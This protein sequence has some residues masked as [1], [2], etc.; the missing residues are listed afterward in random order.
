MAE[1]QCHTSALPALRDTG[2]H[3]SVHMQDGGLHI[4]PVK[5]TQTPDMLQQSEGTK[6]VTNP[7]RYSMG[8]TQEGHISSS[9][10]E[11]NRGAPSSATDK[12]QP[13]KSEH[14]TDR[15][16]VDR[17]EGNIQEGKGH[18]SSSPA[19]ARSSHNVAKNST[20]PSSIH[21]VTGQ[22]D[23]SPVSTP[24]QVSKDDT[25][26]ATTTNP[27]AVVKATG[28]SASLQLK[29]TTSQTEIQIPDAMAKTPENPEIEE[30]TGMTKTW[31]DLK[32]KCAIC[33]A[34]P[35]PECPH[36]GESLQRALQQA[37]DRWLGVQRIR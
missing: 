33:G 28:K 9:S 31:L 26:Q 27:P 15:E 7:E 29:H 13:S 2:L 36:E 23:G 6:I 1:K 20:M 11:W 10:H 4:S 17:I 14:D 25:E 12:A 37:Q 35:Y 16:L 22:Y 5:V 18:E 34:P 24:R 3:A 8:K 19:P 21:R 30:T 32:P